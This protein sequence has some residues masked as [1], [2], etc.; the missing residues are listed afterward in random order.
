MKSLNNSFSVGVKDGIPI[1]LGYLSVSFAFGIFA[2]SSGLSILE[3]V[4]ISAFNLTSAGQLAAV[5]II[6]GGGSFIE[7]ILSQLIINARY[8]LM[9]VSLSQKLGKSIGLK[10]RLLISY[11]N[12]DEIFAVSVSKGEPVGKRYM[13]GLILP[14]FL[15]WTFG[16][17][18]GAFAGNILPEMVVCALQIAIYAMFIAIVVPA[19]KDNRAVALSAAIAVALSCAFYFAPFLKVIPSGFSIIIIAVAVSLLMAFIAPLPDEDCEEV[20]HA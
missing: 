4:M 2:V 17:L 3:A 20:S 13:M 1:G 9:S 6:A 19:A 5:P 7:L 12:T 16:T 11:A 8:A 14:P 18:F 10:E 15:G